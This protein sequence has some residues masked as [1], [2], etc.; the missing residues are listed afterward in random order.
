MAGSFAGGVNMPDGTSVMSSVDSPADA[1][2]L[3][4]V[5]RP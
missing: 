4:T 2:V 1:C 5:A 3:C